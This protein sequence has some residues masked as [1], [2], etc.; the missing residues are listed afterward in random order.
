MEYIFGVLSE[1]PNS[2]FTIPVPFGEEYKPYFMDLFRMIAIQT[3]VNIMFYLSDPAKNTLFSG[4]YLK[5]LFFV[6]LGVSVYWLVFRN[7]LTF[8]YVGGS[9]MLADVQVAEEVAEVAEVAIA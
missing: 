6:L 8:K 1:N 2:L 5:T 3:M 4:V 9:D 7:L